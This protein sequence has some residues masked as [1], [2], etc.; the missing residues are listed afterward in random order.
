MLNTQNKAQLNTL[1]FFYFS[2]P[3]AYSQNELAG[4]L[5]IKPQNLTQILEFLLE[6]GVVKSFFKKNRKFWI[7]NQKFEW[8]AEARSLAS[9]YRKKGWKD[10]F[11]SKATS[12]GEIKAL[13]LSGFFCGKPEGLVDMLF[14]GRVNLKKLNTFLKILESKVGF[15]VNYSIMSPQ[16]FMLRKD[17][18]DKFVRDIFDYKHITVLD[19]LN[20]K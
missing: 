8:V 12:L 14:V 4:I 5:K 2:M 9:K 10:V 11:F 3:R 17:T 6:N 1:S 20:K 7:L 13:Y 19:K 15:E 16:E 18:F